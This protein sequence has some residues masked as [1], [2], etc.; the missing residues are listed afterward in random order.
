MC[1]LSRCASKQLEVGVIMPSPEDNV[2]VET[3]RRSLSYSLRSPIVVF[4]LGEMNV[5]ESQG[6]VTELEAGYESDELWSSL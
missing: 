6:F 4:L 1:L 2:V 3:E 5:Q